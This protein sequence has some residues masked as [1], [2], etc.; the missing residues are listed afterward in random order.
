MYVLTITAEGNS[1]IYFLG[2]ALLHTRC[3]SVCVSYFV[4]YIEF[5]EDLNLG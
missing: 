5:A 1:C 3:E 2:A 4:Y